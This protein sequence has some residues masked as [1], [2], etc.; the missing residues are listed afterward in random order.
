MFNGP[1]YQPRLHPGTETAGFGR[2]LRAA[3]R[4][5]LVALV[6]AAGL[7]TVAAAPAAATTT[8]EC[9]QSGTPAVVALAD[10]SFYID[11]SA[12]LDATYAGY[13]VR[14]GAAA[15]NGLWLTLDGFTGGSVGLAPGQPGTVAQPNI[16]AG[17]ANTSYLLLKGAAATATPQTHTIRLSRGYPTTANTVCQ[18][19]F[20]YS[21]VYEAIKAL[22]NK[23]TSVTADAPSGSAHIGDLMTVT[24]TGNT[25][26]LGAG[27]ANDPGVL[28]YAPDALSTFPAGAWRLEQTR[29]SISPDG[30]APPTTYTNRLYLAGASGPNRPYTAQ[31]AFRAIGPADNP[32]GVQPVQYI[33]SGTQVKH[34]DIGGGVVGSLPIVSRQ[35]NVQLAKSASVAVLPATG[36]TV[37]YTVTAAN[38]G[39][40]GATLDRIADTLP[41]GASY[42]PGTS[43]LNG[44]SVAEPEVASGGSQLTW[45]G[46]MSVPAGGTVALTYDVSIPGNAGPMT[47]SAISYYGTAQIDASRDVTLSDPATAT[48]TVLEAAGSARAVDDSATTNANTAVIVSV[49]SNDR[50]S[51][52]FP[53]T[54]SAVGTPSHGTAAS[55]PDGTIAY[56][57]TASYAGTDTFTYTLSDGYSTATGTVSVMINPTARND[58]YVTAKNTTL[59]ASS[60]LANDACTGCTVSLVSGP[61]VGSGPAAG[62]LTLHTDGTFTYGAPNQA[63]ALSFVYRATATG[64]ASATATVNISV[65]AAGPD[66]ATTAYNTAVTI[67]VTA[68]DTCVGGGSNCNIS[69]GTAPSHGTANY[70]GVNVV[71]TPAAGYWGID[72]FAYNLNGGAGAQ[73][74]V[75][76]APPATTLQTTFGVAASGTV[77]SSSFTGVSTFSC[78]GCLYSVAASPTHGTVAVTA[79]T[80]AL[81]YTPDASFAGSD[82]FGYTVTEP[83]SGLN[84]ASTVAVAVGPDAVAD[85]FT[86][87]VGQ[88]ATL[89]VLA[90][91]SCPATC[92]VSLVTGT[93]PA[94]ATVTLNAGNTF[95]FSSA[96]AN[97][98][99]PI[100]FQYRVTSSVAPG[101]R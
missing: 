13:T 40:A 38:V 16:T 5:L 23:V 27:P 43:A 69:A 74:T 30:V 55:K 6:T 66:Q 73:V 91:D 11:S 52:G 7:S 68:N 60:V 3:T 100:S 87:P 26:T 93:A 101:G 45:S 19:T 85:T 97:D 44:V 54:V 96:P 61:T 34:T 39:G 82:S 1:S 62:A 29:M 46:P 79:A 65:N 75:L 81:V 14:A 67:P 56:T 72:T 50:S 18:R 83:S 59:N 20:T 8:P 41:P 63:Q 22:A 77:T 4:V 84:V 35:A 57:P 92:T 10:P 58:L 9:G 80:G 88:S 21:G 49:L 53:L 94:G 90:N 25:G 24:V 12:G 15:E 78:T 17:S 2:R 33:A 36:G 89:D 32:S 51:G 42:R 86:T 48:V 98:I 76:V 28:S 47:N 71:Y 37:K 70:S 64:G 99:G 95:T 31:Y